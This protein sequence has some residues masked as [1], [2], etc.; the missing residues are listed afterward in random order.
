MSWLPRVTGSIWEGSVF[1]ARICWAGFATVAGWPRL[2]R[3]FE[4]SVP[5]MFFVGLPAAGTF[6]PVMRFVCGAGFAARQV[7]AA[8]SHTVL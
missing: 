4:S 3:S 6:G 8:M 5:G 7:S 1:S 2:S